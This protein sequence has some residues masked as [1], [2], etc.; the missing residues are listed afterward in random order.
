MV[1]GGTELWESLVVCAG[2]LLFAGLFAYG[3]WTLMNPKIQEDVFED[4][5]DYSSV[6]NQPLRRL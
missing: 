4:N 3:S 1:A 5:N 2:L 6:C